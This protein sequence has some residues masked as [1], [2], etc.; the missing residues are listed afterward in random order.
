MSARFSIIPARAIDDS[1]LSRGALLV[2]CTL[3]TYGDKNGWCWPSQ[4]AIAK[5]IRLSRQGV[6]QYIAELVKLGYIEQRRQTREGK[7]EVASLYRVIMD[8]ELPAEFDRELTTPA[9]PELAPPAPPANPELARTSQLT[10]QGTTHRNAPCERAQAPNAPA[11][12]TKP[13][14]P[15]VEPTPAKPTRQAKAKER[16]QAPSAKTTL[17]ADFAI[18]PEL[19]AWADTKGY[20][21]LPQHLEGFKDKAQAKGYQYSDWNAAFRNAVRDD[22]AGLR[23]PATATPRN[24]KPG[25][26]ASK[27]DHLVESG[28]QAIEIWLASNNANANANVIEG[29]CHEIH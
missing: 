25:P 13:S 24:G 26:F 17:P 23:S 20:G 10:P 22:W 11:P 15:E 29:E 28:R 8:G 2:L 1:R 27:H 19:Q 3:G 4:G 7:G 16:A 18:T 6:S 21:D 5:R 9:N 12:T 14:A